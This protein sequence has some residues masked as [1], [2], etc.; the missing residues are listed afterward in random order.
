MYLGGT[1]GLGG[2]G[3]YVS[4]RHSHVQQY[5]PPNLG[6]LKLSLLRFTARMVGDQIRYTA[7]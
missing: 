3:L 2:C 1:L 6:P 4:T 7:E 5:H